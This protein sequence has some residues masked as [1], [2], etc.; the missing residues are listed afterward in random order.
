MPTCDC[1][2]TPEDQANGI[3]A[4]GCSSTVG[5]ADNPSDHYGQ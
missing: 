2:A 4:R 1:G 5:P 3:H